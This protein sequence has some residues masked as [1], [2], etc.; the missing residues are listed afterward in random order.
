M[1]RFQN[2]NYRITLCTFLC[3]CIPFF[4]IAQDDDEDKEQDV[5]KTAARNQVDFNLGGGIK[6]LF[7]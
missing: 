3:V 6:F 7:K 1:K 4:A 5:D 2:F